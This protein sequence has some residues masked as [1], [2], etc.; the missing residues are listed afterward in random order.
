MTK[1]PNPT[2]LKGRTTR[3]LVDDSIAKPV[4]LAFAE[5][6]ELKPFIGKKIATL[7][8]EGRLSVDAPEVYA[9]KYAAHVKD[10]GGSWFDA[11]EPM[12][13]S[14]GFFD[15]KTQ[16]ISLKGRTARVESAVHEGIHLLAHE[17]FRRTFGAALDEGATSYFTDV[18]L[19]EQGLT[20]GETYREQR[21]VAA[22][23]VQAAG[24]APT[25]CAYFL[26]EVVPLMNG[27]VNKLSQKTVTE[28]RMAMTEN[29]WADAAKILTPAR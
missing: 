16:K 27:L 20:A 1:L 18:I 5:S 3:E 17:Q 13:K 9:H 22:A 23:L 10:N 2:A 11:K 25:A 12:D 29:R 14:G 15:P 4:D 19:D 28:W 24:L 26:G 8:V 7:R 6:V 21:A